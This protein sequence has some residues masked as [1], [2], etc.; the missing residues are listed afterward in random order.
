MDINMKVLDKLKRIVAAITGV[1]I[2]LFV[3][4]NLLK[5]FS[6]WGSFSLMVGVI[7]AAGCIILAAYEVTEEDEQ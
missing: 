2:M 6:F 7:L 5:V 4:H 3:A 1:V